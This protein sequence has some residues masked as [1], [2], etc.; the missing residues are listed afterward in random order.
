MTEVIVNPLRDIPLGN[1]VG[2]AFRAQAYIMEASSSHVPCTL[3]Q[4]LERNDKIKTLNSCL[5][6]SH[7]CSVWVERTTV[8]TSITKRPGELME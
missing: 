5:H 6:C 3:P 4:S 7:L 2:G 8:G 1:L